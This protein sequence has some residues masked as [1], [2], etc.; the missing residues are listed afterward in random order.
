[1]RQQ[2]VYASKT[3][4]LIAPI[5]RT[6][7]VK[8]GYSSMRNSKW[9][10]INIFLGVNQDTDVTIG[11]MQAKNVNGAADKELIMKAGQVFSCDASASA[12][13]DKDKWS[14]VTLTNPDAAGSVIPV[15]GTDG[16]LYK[17]YVHNDELDADNDYDCLTAQ[18]YLLSGSGAIIAAWID[19]EEPRFEG[20]ASNYLITPS[21]AQDAGDKF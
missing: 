9:A 7:P 19:F 6:T 14:A 21:N 12:E 11:L 20:D 17:I 5:S 10:C 15:N 2:G 18:I 13:S 1:M 8:F 3:R 4:P 16:T